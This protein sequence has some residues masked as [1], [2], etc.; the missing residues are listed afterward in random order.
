M[1]TKSI[2]KLLFLCSVIFILGFSIAHSALATEPINVSLENPIG[3]DTVTGLI[4]KITGWVLGIAGSIM[5]IVLIFAGFRYLTAG[6][7]EDRAKSA[8][9]MLTWAIIGIAI[10]VGAAAITNAVMDALGVPE[11]TTGG[12]GGTANVAAALD[13]IELAPEGDLNGDGEINAG[14]TI[15]VVANLTNNSD[16]DIT[17]NNVRLIAVAAGSAT[18]MNNL[19]QGDK[20]KVAGASTLIADEQEILKCGYRE[21]WIIRE[22]GPITV[23]AR[24]TV[25]LHSEW[26]VLNIPDNILI[27]LE[28]SDAT[29]QQACELLGR[30]PIDGGESGTSG[31]L[32]YV[33]HT[34]KRSSIEN[35]SA[36]PKVAPGAEVTMEVCLK[37]TGGEEIDD[38][39]VNLSPQEDG[40]SVLNN[41]R[42]Y[43]GVD[44]EEVACKDY[45]FSIAADYK[46]T[47]INFKIQDATSDDKVSESNI[48]VDLGTG[49]EG[50][51][52]EGTCNS[53]SGC[54]TFQEYTI[55][56]SS[57][58]GSRP[59]A[60]VVPG[61]TVMMRVYLENQ[62]STDFGDTIQATLTTS[63]SGVTVT[64]NPGKYSGMHINKHEYYGY[65]FSIPGSYTKNS[66]NF[67]IQGSKVTSTN[68]TVPIDT[69]F[70]Q[71]LTALY[72]GSGIGNT[73][74]VK[75]TILHPTFSIKNTGAMALAANQDFNV[76]LYACYSKDADACAG[77]TSKPE[78]KFYSGSAKEMS[79]GWT[80]IPSGGY[81][82]VKY[83]LDFEVKEQKNLYLGIKIDTGNSINESNENDNT[84]GPYEVQIASWNAEVKELTLDD[85]PTQGTKITYLD[86]PA[87]T[88]IVY[89][90]SFKIT[91]TGTGNTN[92]GSTDF[93]YKIDLIDGPCA[94]STPGLYNS[95]EQ[96]LT[97]YL[98]PGNSVTKNLEIDTRQNYPFT[99]QT[100]KS[101]RVRIILKD[102]STLEQIPNKVVCAAPFTYGGEPTLTYNAKVLNASLTTTGV[103]NYLYVYGKVKND[104]TKKADVSYGWSINKNSSGAT[105]NFGCLQNASTYNSGETMN[106]GSMPADSEVTITSGHIDK[107]AENGYYQTVVTANVPGDTDATDNKKCSTPLKIESGG[108]KPPPIE[109][110]ISYDLEASKAVLSYD[111]AANRFKTT[112]CVKNHSTKNGEAYSGFIGYYSWSLRRDGIESV[113]ASMSGFTAGS[114]EEQ[115]FDA[116]PYRTE[117]GEYRFSLI[118]SVGNQNIDVKPGNDSIWSNTVTI[119]ETPPVLPPS[120]PADYKTEI[121]TYGMTANPPDNPGT[122]NYRIT[123][124]NKSTQDGQPIR[125]NVSW[126][127]K[128]LR[129]DSLPT[130]CP[131]SGGSTVFSYNTVIDAQ[132]GI[133]VDMYGDSYKP[134]QEG[135][136]HLEAWAGVSGY[137]DSKSYKCTSTVHHVPATSAS[138]D[139]SSANAFALPLLDEQIKNFW[140]KLQEV[141]E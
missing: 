65:T 112:I 113:E 10:I 26:T 137:E 6:A 46:P 37:N 85:D 78:Y 128:M 24:E 116:N 62:T 14:D 133:F 77:L 131:A 89:R 43:A 96:Q 50:G 135:Y 54:V 99:W 51:I 18:G 132:N 42:R 98:L 138:L 57:I 27:Q 60:K 114:G 71:N 15:N 68:F 69:S 80:S 1:N 83:P 59:N 45:D 95:Q 19:E 104:S 4:N 31:L 9:K 11:T 67:T 140:Q 34:V 119:S 17:L 139:L 97:G 107:P 21:Y 16:Q 35:E 117:L 29:Q 48:K 88:K 84:G 86:P 105:D 33:S 5:M 30:V 123:Y 87:N 64:N 125:A 100:G 40:V 121:S 92:L 23:K 109:P 12:G 25:G 7:N 122:Y 93:Y 61:A 81:V 108:T 63:D 3:T 55:Q 141:I 73:L 58:G 101:Y 49:G 13:T 38:A 53:S 129:N 32:S 79:G 91:N 110:A 102:H 75:G 103:T 74:V 56:D 2:F 134:S 41:P 52:E 106:A 120:A 111:P 8:K 76:E 39:N 126:G 115:C 72:F 124:E 22:F 136:Y 20:K 36:E 127:V 130:G 70:K 47:S 94:E 44:P 82:A 118:T 28:T 90:G 66:I